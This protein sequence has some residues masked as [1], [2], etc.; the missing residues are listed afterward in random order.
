MIAPAAAST[1]GPIT[2][3]LPQPMRVTRREWT[4]FLFVPVPITR[5]VTF[6]AGKVIITLDR[7]QSLGFGDVLGLP[8]VSVDRLRWRFEGQVPA[9]ATVSERWMFNGAEHDTGIPIGAQASDSGGVSIYRRAFLAAMAP[10][11]QDD[12][13]RLLSYLFSME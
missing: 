3:V 12:V 2:I 4:S 6:P 7:V 5:T 8:G 1:L 13:K 11:S 10:R 9:G